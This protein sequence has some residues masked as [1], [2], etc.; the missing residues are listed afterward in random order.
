MKQ[1]FRATLDMLA[2]TFYFKA[3]SSGLL[4]SSLEFRDPSEQKPVNF[5]AFV[6]F[7]I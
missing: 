3:L 5:L 2:Q 1:E 4:H 7:K 6:S